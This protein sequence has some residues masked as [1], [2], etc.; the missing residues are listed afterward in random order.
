M[1]R[2]IC[3]VDGHVDFKQNL[4]PR[5]TRHDEAGG[6]AVGITE[7]FTENLLHRLTIGAVADINTQLA[8]VVETATRF[9]D[10]HA[11]VPHGV[12]GLRGCILR[13]AAKV[14]HGTAIHRCSSETSQVNLVIRAHC[15]AGAA[16]QA[17]LPEPIVSVEGSDL[18]V[19]TRF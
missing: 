17:R 12:V 4:R 19:R 3:E 10:R 15:P 13:R 18:R 9:F 7:M 8:D 11:R 1:R 2:G 5:E 14:V 16:A 6:A